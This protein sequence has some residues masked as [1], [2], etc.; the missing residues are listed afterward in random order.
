MADETP[1]PSLA[2]QR[3]EH[4][5]EHQIEPLRLKQLGTGAE[6]LRR[7]AATST[8]LDDLDVVIKLLAVEALTAIVRAA[9]VLHP[10]ASPE[11]REVRDAWLKGDT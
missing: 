5:K 9:V 7:T 2:R 4:I 10:E 3:A 1:D 11:L 6:L 8:S